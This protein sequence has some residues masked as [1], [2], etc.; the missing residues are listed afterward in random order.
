MKKTSLQLLLGILLLSFNAQAQEFSIKESDKEHISIHFELIDFSIDTLQINGETM[1][2][3]TSKGITVPNDY[4][5]PNLITFC[6][7]IAVPQ[8]AEAVVKINSK[9]GETIKGINIAPSSGSQ[10]ENEAIRPFF[11]DSKVYSCDALYPVSE[12]TTANPL[13][14]RGVDVIHLGVCPVQ[15]NPVKKEIL[16]HRDI[17]IEIEFKG[18]N[19]HFGDDRLRS[20][21]WDPILKNNIL[22]HTCLEPIDYEKRMQGWVRDGAT[23][24]EYAIITPSNAQFRN[25]AQELAD[26]R[27]R[28]GI[29]TKVYTME[30]LGATT[31]GMMRQWFREVYDTWDIPPAAVCLLGEQG[32]DINQ[33][34]PSFTVPHPKDTW[35]SSDNPYADINDD[36]LPDICFSRLVAENA[37]ELPILVGKQME[38][39]YTNPNM[40]FYSYTHP[41]TA[42]G[43]DENRWFQ[44]TIETIGGYLRQHAKLPIRINNI[45][46]GVPD[47][48]WSNA[49]NTNDI[50]SYFGP[51]GIGY[52]PSTPDQL[53]NW[54]TGTKEEVIQAINAGTYIIQHRDHG[55]TNKW[56]QP[57]IYVSDFTRINNPNDKMPFMI[58]VNC[59]TGEFDASSQCFTEGLLRMTRDG[60]N[61]GIVGAISPSAQ[62]YSFANDIFLWG[63]W[64]HFDPTFLP[65]YGPC[66]DHVSEWMPAFANV[67]GKY[68]LEQQVFPSTNQEMRVTTYNIFHTHA[69]A[70]LRVYTDIPQPIEVQH[71]PTIACFI[72][73][74]ITA[75][76]GTQIAITC[77]R[78]R[79][80]HILDVVEA[81]G[82]EQ[83]IYI[84]EN[85]LPSE[86]IHLTITGLNYLRHEEDLVM[87]P[88]T[89]PCVVTYDYLLHSDSLIHLGQDLSMDVML[90][91]FGPQASQAGTSTLYSESEFMNITGS[92]ISFPALEPSDTI[93]L[94]NAFQFSISNATPDGTIIPFGVMTEHDG[95]CYSN[96]GFNIKVN[97]PHITSLISEIDDYSGN[98]NNLLDPGDYAHIKFLVTNDGHYLANEIDF[99]LNSDGYLRILTPNNTITHLGVGESA[100]IVFDVFVEWFAGETQFTQLTLISTTEQLQS[101]SH[102][103]CTI[104]FVTESFETGINPVIWDNNPNHPWTIT[105]STSFDG[106]VC[107]Q[108]GTITDNETS[109]LTLQYTS[110]VEGQIKFCCKVSSEANYD[111]LRFYID[112][113]E[114]LSMAGES[115]WYERIFNVHPGTHTFRWSYEKD[116]SVSN[117][118]DCAWLDYITM[119]PFIDE[120]DEHSTNILEVHPNPVTDMVYLSIEN[121]DEA[122]V[123]V[124]D[125]Q[126]RLV[127]Q[128]KNTNAISFKGLNPGVYHIK[129]M[130]GG[131]CWTCSV[132][133]M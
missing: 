94:E 85:V 113:I 112:D 119:P 62:S 37:S 114:R 8:G 92:S 6:R 81:T 46:N 67:A 5:M 117:G 43:W 28:Q 111:W 60:H 90:K 58:S 38:Y 121:S 96:N 130:K 91:N 110:N 34:V 87:N 97:S 78:N 49:S 106:Q 41:I 32:D 44:I 63:I 21:Y 33:F 88:L 11:K 105:N 4:G 123:S 128:E 65:D 75:P 129:V 99:E 16:V 18:G 98:Q 122:I 132:I 126:G 108:S 30:D 77:T 53:G 14:L 89:S 127:I 102:F 7:F 36:N 13:C 54:D 39:E 56:Y 95:L 131:T 23:G 57:E 71:D 17:D 40:D 20:P 12:V 120:V 79:A 29:L 51:N 50:V 19:G 68:F 52:I 47:N 9:G 115:S 84:M 101:T 133:K 118:S 70:F 24:C 124:F 42:C 109:A 83:E 1:H 64:D 25:A 93:V 125:E 74:H 100:E 26:Y 107:A 22:N 69:D 72:P 48:V 73:F 82:Q 59:K 35:C 104:G 61:A 86:Q 45:Y 10:C 2:S 80:V 55:W 3:I 103:D 31:P 15:F 116:L 76:E 27:S 66:A